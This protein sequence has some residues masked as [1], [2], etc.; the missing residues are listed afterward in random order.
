[1]YCHLSHK[2]S[3]RLAYANWIIIFWHPQCKLCYDCD[4]KSVQV[5][6]K[7]YSRNVI[8]HALIDCAH[9]SYDTATS[10]LCLL[11]LGGLG[12]M[13]G[14]TG[15]AES[16]TQVLEQV[17]Y[18]E[19]PGGG[20]KLSSGEI[21][22][23][24]QNWPFCG[25]IFKKLHYVAKA[26]SLSIFLSQ[27][28]KQWNAMW[29]PTQNCPNLFGLFGYDHLDWCGLWNPTLQSFGWV[30]SLSLL[31]CR[32]TPSP[33]AFLYFGTGRVSHPVP[34]ILIFLMVGLH[35]GVKSAAAINLPL[36]FNLHR[37]GHLHTDF[38]RVA[39]GLENGQPEFQFENCLRKKNLGGQ[40]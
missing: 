26:M 17:S 33:L 30:W 8:M 25:S 16:H 11:G 38:H 20:Y 34:W 24:V 19:T 35:R 29:N 27:R 37:W 22:N 13:P 23:L 32:T 39:F 31:L 10:H 28:D 7:I 2:P 6:F 21:L 3:S 14:V 1:M 5:S 9:A 18:C 40:L 4:S 36:N 12:S 15:P